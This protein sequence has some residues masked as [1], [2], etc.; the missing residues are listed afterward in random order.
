METKQP[1]NQVNEAAEQAAAQKKAQ[2]IK[3]VKYAS[4]AVAA[5]VAVVLVYIY[6]VRNPAIEG[7]NEAIGQADFALMEA[8]GDPAKMA[9]VLKKYEAVAQNYGQDAGNRAN[10]MAA[11]GLYEKG[12]YQKCLEYLDAYS[13][14]GAVIDAAAYSLKGDCY[15]NL[16]KYDEAIS[17]F[18]K[19]ISTSNENPQLTPYFMSKQARVYNEKKEHAK[20]LEIYESIKNDYPKYS[21]MDV[22]KFI[23]RAKALA[24]KK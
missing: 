2:M 13:A 19:A 8:N 15:V 10:L 4:I 9:E 23:E 12:D 6:A 3:A 24:E 18:G 11:I 1:Q 5:I 22:D 17:A 16:K 7:G 14:T 21:G 20:E